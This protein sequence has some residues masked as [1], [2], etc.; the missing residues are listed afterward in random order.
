MKYLLEKLE[1]QLHIPVSFLIMPVF[2]L[3]IPILLSTT[4]IGGHNTLG[5]GII[6]GLV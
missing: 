5:L 1:H 3:T 2:A 6:C 4:M